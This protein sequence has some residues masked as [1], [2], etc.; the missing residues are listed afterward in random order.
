MDLHMYY[1]TTSITQG[2]CLTTHHTQKMHAYI[3]VLVWYSIRINEMGFD[4]AYIKKNIMLLKNIYRKV[5]VGIWTYQSEHCLS[6]VYILL[7]WTTWQATEYIY[8]SHF[9]RDLP[10]LRLISDDTGIPI[11]IL[12]TRVIWFQIR[13]LYNIVADHLKITR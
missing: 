1:V 13:K 5:H 7:F 9:I 6:S 10:G 3:H 11:Y 4:D 2:I 8:V 12:C